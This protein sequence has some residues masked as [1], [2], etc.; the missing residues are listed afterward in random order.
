MMASFCHFRSVTSGDCNAIEVHN[1][2]LILKMMGVHDLILKI[3]SMV[4]CTK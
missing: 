3:L 1:L 2:T 4:G